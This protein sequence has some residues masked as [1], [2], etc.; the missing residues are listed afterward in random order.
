MTADAGVNRANDAIR[1]AAAYFDTRNFER[2]REVL[3][4]ALTEQPNNAMLLIHHAR[5]EYAL[6]NYSGAAWSAHAALSVAPQH[7]F[8]MRIYAL[9]LDCLGRSHE[10]LWLAWRGVMA[11]PNEPLQHWTY[12]ELLLK[13]RQYV[14][15]LVVVDEALRLSPN[16]VDSLVLRGRILHSLGRL[17]ESD[18]AYR[19]ALSVDPDNAEALNNLAVNRFHLGKFGRALRGFLGAAGHDPSLGDLARRNVGAVLVR[20]LRRATF[21]SVLVC[22][23]VDVVG[24]EQKANV[25]TLGWRVLTGLATAA[26]ICVVGWLIRSIPRQVLRSVL[27]ERFFLVVRLAYALVAVAVGAWVTAFGGPQWAMVTGMLL[28]FLGAAIAWVGR[29]AGT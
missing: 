13:A 18:E 16:H 10:A 23:L 11:H 1:I 2:A 6:K 21:L 19:N 28:M 8:A 3:R 27:R 7:E 22:L 9:A 17:P 15:A 26:L 4:T 25:T 20:V 14:S 29:V 12:A 5:A 24:S